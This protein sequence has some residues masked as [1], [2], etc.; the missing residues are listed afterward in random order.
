MT[1]NRFFKISFLLLTAIVAAACS[2]DDEPEYI[3]EIRMPNGKYLFPIRATI[4]AENE[5]KTPTRVS[6][7]ETYYSAGW[8]KRVSW[9]E[10]DSI[11][12]YNTTTGRRHFFVVGNVSEEY[13]TTTNTVEHYANLYS[14]TKASWKEGKNTLYAVYPKER[15]KA[16]GS[17][18]LDVQ[19]PTIQKA[20]VAVKDSSRRWVDD[21]HY[22]T[23]ANNMTYRC[24]NVTDYSSLIL[25]SNPEITATANTPDTTLTGK[26]D[27]R[28]MVQGIDAV[29]EAPAEGS[30]EIQS[31]KI[32]YSS[33]N[34]QPFTPNVN[35]TG[36]CR[37]NGSNLNSLTIMSDAAQYLQ[38]DLPYATNSDA[39]NLVGGKKDNTGTYSPQLDD[40]MIVRGYLIRSDLSG[41]YAK[42]TVTCKVW[43]AD[44]TKSQM[45]SFY[46]IVRYQVSAVNN[47]IVHV[48]MGQI[49]QYNDDY[50]D[51]GLTSGILWGIKNL[52]ADAPEAVG[53]YY[54]WGDTAP[55]ANFGKDYY[56]YY[57]HQN[58]NDYFN[59]TSG[60]DISGSLYDVAH[61]TYH[62][63][64]HLPTPADFEELITQCTWTWDG[65]RN[66]FVVTGTNGNSIFLPAG[67]YKRTVSTNTNFKNEVTDEAGDASNLYYW[68]GTRNTGTNVQK[69]YSLIVFADKSIQT[70]DL[71]LRE[72]GELI[73]PVRSQ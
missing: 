32:E 52:G 18:G 44:K 72:C 47:S 21:I 9:T 23:L 20:I 58:V 54:A 41:I 6:I 42:I 51:L 4:D 34:T 26:M 12:A 61:L 59:F 13:N 25:A 53:D 28:V 22:E 48:Y 69:A 45:H 64:W 63:K 40:R 33:T 73:R 35:V 55:S 30:A 67:G 57:S 70:V 29:I 5:T 17:V 50:V 2:N 36:V 11:G 56:Q 3:G 65:T 71:K 14:N 39:C 16:A 27:F 38:I 31:V 7:T 66:G 10:G 68:T 49:P 19:I 1:M 24:H 8:R 62:G 60:A 15:V 46:K 37:Y 43:N